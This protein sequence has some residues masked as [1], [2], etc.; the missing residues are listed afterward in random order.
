[1]QKVL[2]NRR[3]LYR[4]LES[5]DFLEMVLASNGELL[6]LMTLQSALHSVPLSV[7]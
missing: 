1:M 5:C 7:G 4:K 6:K 3:F 2:E